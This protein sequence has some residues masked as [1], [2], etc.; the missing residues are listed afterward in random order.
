MIRR[1]LWVV[2]AGFV[3]VSG[4]AS[5]H[6]PNDLDREGCTRRQTDVLVKAMEQQ[7]VADASSIADAISRTGSVALYGINFDTGKG[8]LQSG[9][10]AVLG[11][12][13]KVLGEHTDW[14]FE[15]Q[16]HTDNVGAAAAN[17]AL[18]DQRARAVVA[19]L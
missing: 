5:A 4:P 11:E 17:L 3:L 6:K 8:T 7:L 1:Y 15:V 19:W 2:V 16:G 12:I 13:V 18:S 9:S 10:E 14:K